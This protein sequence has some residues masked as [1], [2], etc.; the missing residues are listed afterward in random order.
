MKISLYDPL[1]QTNGATLNAV[2]LFIE[3]ICRELKFPPEN[4][5]EVSFCDEEHY[6]QKIKEINADAAYT[7]NK[8]HTGFGKTIYHKNRNTNTIIVRSIVFIAIGN[9]FNKIGDEKQSLS[10]IKKILFHEI[11]HCIV[12]SNSPV[13]RLAYIPDNQDI[14]AIYQYNFYVLIDEYQANR[15]IKSLYNE[16]GIHSV[17]SFNESMFSEACQNIEKGLAEKDYTFYSYNFW[18]FFIRFSSCLALLIDYDTSLFIDEFEKI[19]WPFDCKKF[20]D[21]VIRYEHKQITEDALF[22]HIR[23]IFNLLWVQ[24]QR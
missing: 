2:S 5:E 21:M 10:A 16:S 11:G 1:I 15:S 3:S 4:I 9:F 22:N 20:I 23:N 17:V 18:Q 19:P 14:Q 13:D 24:S 6:G 12:N 8:Q 7:E